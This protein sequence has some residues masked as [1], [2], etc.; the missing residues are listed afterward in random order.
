MSPRAALLSGITWA[1]ASGAFALDAPLVV[2]ALL[3]L[4]ATLL[5]PGWG[6]AGRLGA[7]TWLQRWIDACWASIL[8]MIPSVALV[9]LLGGDGALLLH[10]SLAWGLLGAASDRGGATGQGI[11]GRW[12]TIGAAFVAIALAGLAITWAP[13]LQRPLDAYWYHPQADA[14][15]HEPLPWAPVEGFGPK[16]PLGWE[17]ARA[18]HLPDPEG[19]GGVIEVGEAGRMMILLRGPLGA[20][21]RLEQ[22]G[23]SA[24]PTRIEADVIEV[25]EEGPV[26]RYMERGAVAEVLEVQPGEL[27]IRVEGAQGPAD[28]YVIPGTDAVW[29]LHADGA[30]RFV[31]YYQLLNIVENLRWAEE[32]TRDR[33]LTVSQ[34]P[35]WSNGMAVVPLLLGGGLVGANLLLLWVLLLLG[36]SATR[37]LAVL[38]P[39]AT[40]PAWLLPG[41]GAAT[42]GKLM[43]EPGSTTFPDPLYAAALIGGIAALKQRSTTRFAIL[44]VCAGALRYPGV[45]ALTIAAGI[46]AALERRLPTRHL[47]ALWGLTAALGL[48]VATIALITGQL[49][50][51]LFILWFETGPEHYHGDYSAGALLARPPEFYATWLRYTGYGLLL[52]LPLAGRGAK[53]VGGWALVYSL[54]LCTIDHF[55]SHYFLPLVMA[56]AVAVGASASALRPAAARWGLPALAALGALWFLTAGVV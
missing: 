14:E 17:E 22:G 43:L 49:Q 31:H 18:A 27:R 24:G 4:P 54:L 45:I 29:S 1:A 37:L 39:R 52:A 38:E 21:L 36:F 6:I 12:E 35:L 40:P 20:S 47:A 50:D 13:T 16:Q 11:A 30:V 7:E 26:A 44:G 32:L 34:P 10:L 3:G 33:W 28:L 53:L 42:V 8:L 19:D 41:L 55:P 25:T 15:G 23:R 48:S 9:R 56:S 5:A 51:W 2:L 46:S